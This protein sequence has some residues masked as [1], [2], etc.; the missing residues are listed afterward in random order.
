MKILKVTQQLFPNYTIVIKEHPTQY[1]FGR[2]K[3]FL[4][5]II[6][7]S[8]LVVIKSNLYDSGY[9]IRHSSLVISATGSS[10][11]EAYILGKSALMFGNNIY[12]L[13]P[14]VFHI[15]Q[16]KES[17]NNNIDSIIFENHDLDDGR[18]IKFIKKNGIKTNLL[19]K[20][21]DNVDENEIYNTYRQL[22][23][24]F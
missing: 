12:R 1:N 15:E 21:A 19:L 17:G 2:T 24:L 4:D 14:N 7:N 8:G 18:Y 6:N 11:F 20:K 9:L 3:E 16:F 22:R 10:L 5:F 23:K 13:L